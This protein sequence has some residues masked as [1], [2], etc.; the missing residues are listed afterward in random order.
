[1]SVEDNAAR[2]RR[3]IEV[4]FSGGD[5]A[6]VDELVAP[7]CIEHQR[8]NPSG[9]E[10]AKE[11]IRT[12]HR[13]LSGFSLTI[14]DLVTDGDMV[15]ARN[16]ARGVNTGSVM[17]HEPTGRPVELDVID[18][19]RFEDGR[20]VEHWGI[21]DQLGMMLQL[22]LIRGVRPNGPEP[23]P[24]GAP[25]GS[26][27][28]FSL[29]HDAA[30]GALKGSFIDVAQ[31]GDDGADAGGGGVVV[32]APAHPAG[33]H[34][35]AVP[36][37]SEHREVLA[38]RDGAGP[39]GFARLFLLVRP[40]GLPVRGGLVPELTGHD[41]PVFHRQHGVHPGPAEMAADGLPVIGHDRDLHVSSSIVVAAGRL[42]GNRAVMPPGLA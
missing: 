36:D 19:A 29:V 38:T 18:I 21:A 15:W 11:V 35:R 20:V 33:D 1:M 8:G 16:R 6:I 30:G 14:E 7:G 40:V 27:Q 24:W 41:G 32:G 25:V 4:G 37:H 5:T 22:G 26:V 31:R 17:G 34:G 42:P 3:L 23:D 2:F 13:W 12:L 9:V 39:V 10:G 28:A